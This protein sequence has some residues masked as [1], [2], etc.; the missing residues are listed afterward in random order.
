MNKLD[1]WIKRRFWIGVLLG[2]A[3]DSLLFI[4]PKQLIQPHSLEIGSSITTIVGG[5]V[6]AGFIDPSAYLVIGGIVA[7]FV[8]GKSIIDGAKAGILAGLTT[9]TVSAAKIFYLNSSHLSIAIFE[10]IA[11]PAIILLILIT[12]GGIIGGGIQ[13]L[14]NFISQLINSIPFK[15][16]I[17]RVKLNFEVVSEHLKDD[18][19]KNT[20]IINF[21]ENHILIL[22]LVTNLIGFLFI[23]AF[24]LPDNHGQK[25]VNSIEI[26]T[27]WENSSDTPFFINV[28]M[29]FNYNEPIYDNTHLNFE[30]VCINITR[31]PMNNE[32]V[33]TPITLIELYLYN[34]VNSNRESMFENPVAHYTNSNRFE[35]DTLNA[36]HCY[37]YKDVSVIS[38]NPYMENQL[39]IGYYLSYTTG[40][41]T[42]VLKGMAG[43]YSPIRALD[44]V[45][46]MNIQI[47]NRI[48][49]LTGVLII[50]GSFPF[51]AALKQLFSQER[52]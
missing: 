45:E 28:S 29:P 12:L 13:E 43:F 27:F 5:A 35:L 1:G 19:L 42:S 37:P 4:F 49:L 39:E 23:A 32:S 22:A 21:I 26:D 38:I 20:K 31:N 9:I 41:K 36:Y 16:I 7:G 8:A 11:F 10:F 25:K 24:F 40:Y 46:E 14:I 15:R 44:S 30:A 52:P 48:L 18:R 50:L 47:N 33:Y 2:A 34:S 3:I 6:V 17:Q 51:F